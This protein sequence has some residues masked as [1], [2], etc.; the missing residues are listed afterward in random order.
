M[1]N[2]SDK[3]RLERL[4]EESREWNRY[5]HDEGESSLGEHNRQIEIGQLRDKIYQE[6]N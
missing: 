4:V 3:Q 2:E 1:A 5:H 6:T